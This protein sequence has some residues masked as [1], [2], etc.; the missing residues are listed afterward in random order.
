MGRDCEDHRHQEPPPRG[1]QL[2]GLCCHVRA[3]ALPGLLVEAFRGASTGRDRTDFGAEELNKQGKKREPTKNR[4]GLNLINCTRHD[5]VM[6]KLIFKVPRKAVL[7]MQVLAVR[8]KARL[9]PSHRLTW[10]LPGFWRSMFLFYGLSD[11]CY[12]SWW[13]EFDH[14]NLSSL[15]LDTG[16]ALAGGHAL[17]PYSNPMRIPIRTARLSLGPALASVG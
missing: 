14:P 11:G 12:D 9:L 10:I 2:G 7:M 4:K 5:F 17:L 13:I 8:K 1:L 16:H 6:T 3:Q 15:N